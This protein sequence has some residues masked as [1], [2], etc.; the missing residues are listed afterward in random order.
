H[1]ST[2]ADFEQL[3]TKLG[4]RVLQRAFLA[5][6][7]PVIAMAALRATQAIYRFARV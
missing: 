5:N 6:G 1:L 7:K 2:P 4:L 3:L